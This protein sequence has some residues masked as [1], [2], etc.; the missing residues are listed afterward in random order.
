MSDMNVSGVSGVYSAITTGISGTSEAAGV[1]NKAAVNN[2]VAAVYEK[3]TE[4]VDKK[5]IYSINKMSA[6][7]RAALVQQLP[8][9]RTAVSA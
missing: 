8:L 4:V 9:M 7:D 6:E 5:A 1:D 2:D 3:S